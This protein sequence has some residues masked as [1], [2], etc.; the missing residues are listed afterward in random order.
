LMVI[1]SLC[2]HLRRVD[3]LRSEIQSKNL[4]EKKLN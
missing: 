4:S 1:N 2:Y 3:S